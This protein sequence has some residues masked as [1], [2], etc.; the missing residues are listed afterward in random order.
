MPDMQSQ[1][2]VK[3]LRDA[4]KASGEVETNVWVPAPVREAIDEAVKAGRFPN[5]R[6]AIVHA[7]KVAFTETS[8]M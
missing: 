4:R 1:A 8:S 3:R 6:T 5:R 7:L 2:R